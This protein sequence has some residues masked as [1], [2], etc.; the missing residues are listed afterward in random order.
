MP[1][2]GD[3]AVRVRIRGRVQGVSYRWW[4]VREARYRGL[5]GWVRNCRDGSVEALFVG[6]AATVEAMVDACRSGPPAAHV[7]GIEQEVAAEDGG[8]QGFTELPTA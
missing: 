5:R 7:T 2:E 1:A 6:E 8:M 4:T 3:V